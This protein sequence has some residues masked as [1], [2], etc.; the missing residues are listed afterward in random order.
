MAAPRFLLKTDLATVHPLQLQGRPVHAMYDRLAELL[1]SRG[2]G[3]AETLFAEPVG[4][5]GAV[6]W[7]GEGNG[8]PRPMASLSASR[9]TEAEGRLKRHLDA[10]TPLLDDP[11]AGPLLKRALVLADTDSIVALDDSVVLTGWG[12]APPD[13]GGDEAA[14]AAQIRRTLGPYSA[15][16]A[17]ADDGFFTT[18]P[19]AIPGAR[20]IAPPLAPPSPVSPPPVPPVPPIR[21]PGPPA[22]GSADGSGRAFWLVPLLIA[23]ALLF[24]CLGFWA[25][26]AH[27]VR[28][29]AGRQVTAPIADEAATRNAIRQQRETNETLERELER[30]RR[31]AAQPN[32]CT[33]DGPLGIQP[34]PERQPVRPEAVPPSVPQQQGQ[35][36]PPF[37]GSLAQ[38]LEH[39][40]VMVV[41]AGP[42]GIGHGSGFFVSGDTIVTN[43]HVVEHADPAQIYVMSTSLG[44]ALPAQLVT[45]SRPAG[46]ADV[47][48]G[49][50]DFAILRLNQPVPGAQPL[51][52]TRSAEKLT[53]VVAA[54]YPASVVRV[55][56]GMRELQ[57]GRLG[58]PPELV[59][60]RG[61]ISTIQRLDSGLVVMPHSADISP[62][63][64]GGPLVDTCGRVV[65]INTFV[66][67][68]TSVADRV[69]YAQKADSMLPWLTQ[70][71]VQV[72]EREGACQPALPTLP[73]LPPGAG[74]TPGSGPG[75]PPSATPTT[76]P[77]GTPPAAAPPTGSPPAG[78]P[79]AAAP[80]AAA[81]PG[82]TPPV[83]SPATLGPAAP[84]G[85]PAAAPG[86][87][88]STTPPAGSP[89][90]NAL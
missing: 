76:P 29:M 30:A 53:D 27:F 32:V 12:L 6:S 2:G 39:A 72:Q 89:A 61:N 87:A 46:G 78:S 57:E 7:Y 88:P 86:S 1:R 40:T 19:N 79:P 69:K 52:L 70:Q 18:A 26:W 58:Q 37:N 38:L 80:P 8:D 62:G 20:P 55:E 34:S 33:P 73:A 28:D 4:G 13:I 83:P 9:R 11:E 65:G 81:P 67:R 64:S 17:A 56:G 85:P 66:S 68:A 63:N 3:G 35:T 14:Q 23:V 84:A 36:V 5:A 75:A 25:A 42:Q 22:A 77:A 49:Q 16:L 45:T 47:E 41:G 51:A 21:P 60:T 82:A 54:G 59:L 15:R 74:G 24:L 50:L 71:N 10:I 44:R 31:A 48:P 43:A 90:G